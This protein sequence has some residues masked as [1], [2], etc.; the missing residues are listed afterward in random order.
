MSRAEAEAVLA[1]L[2]LEDTQL[3]V[4]TGDTPYAQSFRKG[5]KVRM[6]ERCEFYL[7]H[8]ED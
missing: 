5:F 7:C 3:D 4:C 1:A 8:T 2:R 6:V